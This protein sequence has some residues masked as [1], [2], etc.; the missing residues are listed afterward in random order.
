MKREKIETSLNRK[1]TATMLDLKF[2]GFYK[3]IKYKNY[4]TFLPERPTTKPY[5]KIGSI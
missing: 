3:T 5:N 2:T 4:V 1:E